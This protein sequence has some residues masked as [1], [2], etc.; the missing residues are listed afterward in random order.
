MSDA[1]VRAV[2]LVKSYED[3]AIVALRGVSLEIRKGEFFGIMGPSGSGKSTLLNMIGAL[4]YPT[5]GEVVLNGRAL[6]KEPDL[7]AVRA[8]EVGFIFQ[9]HNLIPTL[10][11]IENVEIPM[12]G[13][14][15]PRR[16]RRRIAIQLLERVGLGHR[17]NAIATRLSGGERQRV[18]IARAL[19]NGPGVILADEPTGDVDLKTGE[20]ILACILEE[21]KRTGATLVVVTH[22][23]DI[24]RGADRTVTLADGRTT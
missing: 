16:E 9:L 5:S 15:V 24:L 4:D 17:L 2:D 3:G 11:S 1:A 8:R 14:G 13:V 20:Q 7:D 21:R 22:N 10:T 23:P 6:S 18:S 12:M 19:A